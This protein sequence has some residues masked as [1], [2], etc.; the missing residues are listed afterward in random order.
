MER[1]SPYLAP[2]VA[3]LVLVVA[4]LYHPAPVLQEVS[5][6]QLLYAVPLSGLSFSGM[7]TVVPLSVLAVRESSAMRAVVSKFVDAFAGI[8]DLAMNE[9]VTEEEA[10]ER[11]LGVLSVDEA[12]GR[13]MLFVMS[14][15]LA[16]VSSLAG[17][18]LARREIR[19][20]AVV[21]SITA[22]LLVLIRLMTSYL[23]VSL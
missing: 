22:L 19:D 21:L 15:L 17:E 3:L 14:L 8:A 6:E 2:A 10:S 18:Y 12:I 11:L 9:S 1:S 20:F 5:G 16:A 23:G 4:A 13:A 7:G